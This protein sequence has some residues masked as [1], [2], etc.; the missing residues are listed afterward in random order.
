VYQA[1]TPGFHFT[2]TGFK[3]SPASTLTAKLKGTK[4]AKTTTLTPL[5]ESE[6][7]EQAVSELRQHQLP[8]RNLTLA[9]LALAQQG[10]DV[11]KPKTVTLVRALTVGPAITAISLIYANLSRRVKMA[12]FARTLKNTKTMIVLVLQVGL[13]NTVKSRLQLL[14]RLPPLLHQPLPLKHQLPLLLHPPPP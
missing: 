8:L 12:L 1:L 11:L 3:V 14:H 6:K 10:L 5:A 7:S 13:G 4:V 9:S 2:W